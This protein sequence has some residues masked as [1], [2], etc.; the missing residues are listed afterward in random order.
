MRFEVNGMSGHAA[1]PSGQALESAT[2]AESKDTAARP[3]RVLL[4][5]PS[6]TYIGGQ[7]IQL[8]RLLGRLHDV[9]DLAPAFLPVNP[10][11]PW[12]W[13]LLQAVRFVRT[14]TTSVAYLASLVRTIP[15][16]DVIHAFSASY[17]SFLLAPAPALV[18]ARLR[19]RPAI[20]NY[21]SGEAD[22]HLTRWRRIVLPIM[23]LA[24]RI[25]VPSAYLVDVFA[26]HGLASTSIPNFVE[27]EQWPYR[28]R[29]RLAP[30]FVANRNHE[31]LYNVACVIRAFAR[32]QSRVPDAT[33]VLIGNGAQ[34]SA[35]RALATQLGLRGVSFEG[36]V[37]P[38]AMPGYFDAADIYLNSPNIDNMPTSIL[39]AFAAGVPVIS[40][41]AGGIPYII[42]NGENGVLVGRDDHE[43]MAAAALDLLDDAGR[44]VRLAD[45]ARAEVLERYSWPAVRRA[46]ANAMKWWRAHLRR[47][48]NSYSF[49]GR[50]PCA[51]GAGGA[52]LGRAAWGA[53]AAA[54][55]QYH[56]E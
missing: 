31:K 46:G 43:A 16:F 7:A 49:A 45:T 39:E 15:R 12:P 19:N 28:R 29:A 8:Q 48:E 14:I 40:S 1:K 24:T 20:L 55:W 33:L 26:K 53:A 32:I 41:D 4:I 30:R 11:L 38:S 50:G 9:P 3:L 25:V 37:S 10:Q 23:R 17:W 47:H 56:S 21:R 27:L 22:D 13:S 6:L 35:L 36:Q 18:I 44:A 54:S 2:G 52:C 42:R 51:A 34:H 5:G